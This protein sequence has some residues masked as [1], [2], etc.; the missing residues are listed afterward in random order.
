MLLYLLCMKEVYVYINDLFLCFIK[1][2][3]NKNVLSFVKMHFEVSY[4]K[5]QE[6]KWSNKEKSFIFKNRLC[7]TICK[8]QRSFMHSCKAVF[9][10]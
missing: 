8:E 3:K 1:M 6:S 5:M 4:V 9:Y 10:I 7:M 2:I